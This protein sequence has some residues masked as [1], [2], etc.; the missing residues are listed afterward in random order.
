MILA[1]AIF[2]GC[3]RNVPTAPTASPYPDSPLSL[4]SSSGLLFG[5]VIDRSG[6]CIA[7]ATVQVVRPA[8]GQSIVQRT[9]C[10]VWDYDGGFF[11]TDLTPGVE[12]TLRA[13][14]PGY[15]AAESTF[16]PSSPSGYQ[17][18][19]IVLTRIVVKND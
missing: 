11:F 13:E 1:S 12:L 16:L 14:A 4:R 6:A 8:V 3:S 17:A 9:P 15:M 2:F 7:D 18:V 10:S 5:F 19:S